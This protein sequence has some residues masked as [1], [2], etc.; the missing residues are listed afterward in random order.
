MHTV[1]FG[2]RPKA[3]EK[4]KA[5]AALAGNGGKFHEATFGED[6]IKSF[7]RIS[8]ESPLQLGLAKMFNDGLA[9]LLVDRLL[10]EYI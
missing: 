9:K 7:K 4:L 5:L 10:L 1:A 3:K 2:T 8:V 6:L